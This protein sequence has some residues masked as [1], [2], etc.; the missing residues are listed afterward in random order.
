LINAADSYGGNLGFVDLK[1]SLYS[2]KNK[3]M[4]QLNRNCLHISYG[5]KKIMASITA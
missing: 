3:Y 1:L 5:A 4:L 2:Y